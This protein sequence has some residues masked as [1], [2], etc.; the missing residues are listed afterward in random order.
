MIQDKDIEGKT[1]VTLF[2]DFA[3]GYDDVMIRND[4]DILLINGTS[5]VDNAMR[6][7]LKNDGYPAAMNV[8]KEVLEI[9]P[10]TALFEWII[11]TCKVNP[12]DQKKSPGITADF[13]LHD[14]TT[15]DAFMLLMVLKDNILPSGTKYIRAEPYNDHREK[16]LKCFPERKR[17][18]VLTCRRMS[19]LNKGN[20]GK[21]NFMLP[22]PR[23]NSFPS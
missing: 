5:E 19:T 2:V 11:K 21:T 18:K 9:V 6:K 17:G 16:Y 14:T 23:M 13:G 8:L 1:D 22:Q 10:G 15:S 20:I 4:L 3:V 7:S 12:I